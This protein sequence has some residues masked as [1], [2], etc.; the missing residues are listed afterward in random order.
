MIRIK[1]PYCGLRDHSEFNYIGDAT[2]IRPVS[3]ELANDEEWFDYIYI[4]DNPRGV[5][6][7]YW[8]HIT[9][10]RS[11]VKVLRDTVTHEVL[12]TGLPSDDLLVS[13]EAEK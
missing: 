8:Q 4:R 5:H 6:Q 10:C 3:P 1:C 9:G 7:E 2:K 13:Y 11:Y 12:K